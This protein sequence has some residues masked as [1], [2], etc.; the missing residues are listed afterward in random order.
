MWPN[1]WLL[2][3]HLVACSCLVIT[4][5]LSEFHHCLMGID[6]IYTAST[7]DVKYC[8]SIAPSFKYCGGENLKYYLTPSPVGYEYRLYFC[9][10][11]VYLPNYECRL[12]P[13]MEPAAV[14]MGTVHSFYHP[15]LTSI[16][17][18][19]GA[20]AASFFCVDPEQQNA[21][22][23]RPR[24]SGSSG[25]EPDV[26]H[27]LNLKMSQNVTVSDFKGTVSRDFR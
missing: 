4:P 26:Q 13:P 16:P 3:D 5:N 1:S 14:G 8:L 27:S 10:L 25:S 12:T 20:A 15:N 21:M 22:Q 17:W 2:S 7:C 18:H 19:C 11:P 6:Y 24:I 9:R 23:F